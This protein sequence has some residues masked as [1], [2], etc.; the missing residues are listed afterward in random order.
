MNETIAILIFLVAITTVVASVII[1]VRAILLE[2]KNDYI[3]QNDYTLK[4]FY[5]RRR[6]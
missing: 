3:E 4:D 5:T 1:A 2:N 6:K